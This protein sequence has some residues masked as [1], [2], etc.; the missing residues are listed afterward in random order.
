MT[1]R[2]AKLDDLAAV[3]ALLAR[4]YPR[5]LATDYP[6]SVLDRALPVMIR[7]QPHLLSSQSYYVWQ[8][9]I[10][11]T[12][13]ILGAGG[14][15]KDK[16]VLTKAHIRHVVTD[17]RHL[18]KGIGRGLIGHAL[19]TARNAG[20]QEMECWSTYTAVPFYTA[21]GFDVVGPIDVPMGQGIALPAVRMQQV[22]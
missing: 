12:P 4:S 14:W 18:R 7:A 15:S 16:K 3:D 6:A 17:D 11:E 2:L 5:L 19:Q 9:T 10:G 20:F 13:E 22:F 8:Q 21:M 1:V